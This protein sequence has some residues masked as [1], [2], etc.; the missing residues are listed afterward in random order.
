ML[1]ALKRD[2]NPMAIMIIGP[3][4]PL[5]DVMGAISPLEDRLNAN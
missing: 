1:D 4:S 5:A 3:I 2:Y